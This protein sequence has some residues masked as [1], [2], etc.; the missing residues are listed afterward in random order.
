MLLDPTE[1]IAD[2]LFPDLMLAAEIGDFVLMKKT[3]TALEMEK[4]L[5]NREGCLRVINFVASNGNTLLQVACMEGNVPL[6][7]PTWSCL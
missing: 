4:G 5:M 1:G 6:L 3:M 7:Y 2:P